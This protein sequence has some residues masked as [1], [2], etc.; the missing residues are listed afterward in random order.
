M[1][2]IA[3]AIVLLLF[4]LPLFA[5]HLK[6][7]WIYYEYLGNGS[8]PNTSKYKITVKQYMICDAIGGQIDAEVSL[9]IFDGSSNQLIRTENI[10]LSGTEF[11]QKNDYACIPNPPEVCYRVD[12]Y[13]LTIDLPDNT[14]GY[15]VG[16][17]RCCRINGIVNVDNSGSRGLTYTNKIPG[18]INGQPYRN[19]SSPLFAQKDTAIVCHDAFFTFDFSATD[20]DNDSLSYSFISGFLG[21]NGTPEGVRPNPPV[22]PQPPYDVNALLPYAG[23]YS[24]SFP[25]GSQVTINPINGVISGIAP[26]TIGTYVVAV[27]VNEYRGSVLIG[28]TRKEIHIDVG[29]C[30]LTAAHLMP[31]YISC[32]GYSLT[33]KNETSI[34]AGSIYRWDFGDSKSGI[35]NTSSVPTPTHIYSDTGIYTVKLKITS[36][37]GCEDSTVALAYV[38][39]YFSPGFT[40]QGQCTNT[41][42]QF[43]DT[44]KTSYGTVNAWS[45]NF[46][47]P[48]TNSDTSNIKNPKYTFSAAGNY[49]LVFS[50][51]NNKGCDSTITKTILI[52]DKPDFDVTNDTL[53]CSIDTLQL[54][55]AG[56]GSVF[57]T[58]NYNINNQNN[59]LPL[60]SPDVPTMYY[61]TLT[62]PF[63]CKASDSVFVDVKQFVTVDAG[64]DTGI[65]QGDPIQ[66]DIISDA[67]HYK[68][69]PAA[70]LNNDTIKSPV[71][72]PLATTK[73][74]VT[75]NI[76]K[77]QHTD[78]VTIKVTSYPEGAGIPDTVL[79]L[80]QSVQLNA[81]GGSMYTWSPPFFLNNV[82]IPD[83][84]SSP[85]RT[86]RYIVA[87][88]DTIGCPKP[89]YDTV[90]VNVEKI[91]AN[92][93]PRD[94]SIVV[95]QPLQ[96]NATGGQFYLWTPASGL[97]NPSIG[98]PVATVSDNIDYIVR[99]S[100]ASGCFG[101]DTITVKVYKILPDIYVPNAFTPGDDGTNDVFKPIPIGVR[102]I[103]SFRVYNR[104]GVLVYSSS[105]SA[106]V[107]S[108]GWDGRYKGKPADTAVYVWTVEGI[109]YLNNSIRKKGT[110]T[111]IR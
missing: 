4:T 31:K 52:K 105:K 90:V 25:M 93:G 48:S 42:I 100:N 55:G 107:S 29:D 83:P 16:V 66:L 85:D 80:G 73:F 98:N 101:S 72:T 41:Q 96:L 5:D 111:L 34:P 95:N 65:C 60:V 14:G 71:A 86:I 70:P 68:W 62:D 53:I 33:F 39:P 38:F 2:K 69:F 37:G 109:D 87:I 78:S 27:A 102:E 88:S 40:V 43:T 8:M 63:G 17:Q 59:P 82:N 45:W 28:S 104:W 1:K 12:Q 84:I 7:G 58:P 106:S 94:T 49:D 74:Y 79:C 75:G 46:G 50:V 54:H 44:T 77:C 21:G 13:D 15:I 51:T 20:P 97:N 19:N 110:V 92:A 91:I 36:A 89:I 6:G 67:L 26:N 57:W 35:N 3:L 9:G 56:N 11:E 22:I 18:V 81:S 30:Q 47:D 64:R 61:V 99:A 10:L 32:N 108:I 103:N 23:G 24:G 76:G